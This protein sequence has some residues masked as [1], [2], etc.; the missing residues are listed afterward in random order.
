MIVEESTLETATINSIETNATMN[1]KSSATYKNKSKA[2]DVVY[3]D[4]VKIGKKRT[5]K[6]EMSL[7]Y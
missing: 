4:I 6:W 7:Q 5:V 2:M 1:K 3:S